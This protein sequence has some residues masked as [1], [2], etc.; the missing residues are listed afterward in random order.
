MDVIRKGVVYEISCE[1]CSG[2]YVG[3]T[4]RTMAVRMYEHSPY[5]WNGR[6]D[7]SAVAEH[8]VVVSHE[9]NWTT[10][11]VINT[12]ANTRMRKI[13]EALHI[14]RKVPSMNKDSGMSLSASWYAFVIR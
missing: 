11:K 2:Q 6:T 12:A 9:I 13:K 1:D 10:A 8:A 3:E 14:A 7:V 5:T 4:H